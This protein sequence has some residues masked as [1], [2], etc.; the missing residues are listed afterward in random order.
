MGDSLDDLDFPHVAEQLMARRETR[1]PPRR[2]RPI[3][4]CPDCQ[5][6]QAQ[7]DRLTRLLWPMVDRGSHVM[8]GGTLFV[9]TS[10]EWVDETRKALRETKP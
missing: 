6:K 2:V 3:R 7:I 4:L 8:G 1:R 10:Q 9:H 5:T